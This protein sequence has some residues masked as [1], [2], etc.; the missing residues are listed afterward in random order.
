MPVTTATTPVLE[1]RSVV[2][3]YGHGRA[4]HHALNG[5][6]CVVEPGQTLGVVGESGSGKSTLGEVL[7]GLARPQGGEVLFE[8][9]PVRKLDAAGR[10]RYRRNVQFVFQDPQASM[11]P[12]YTVGR[13][14]AEPLEMFERDLTR[15]ERRTRVG[16]ML[17][18]VGLTADLLDKRPAELSGGQCQRVAIARAL[19]ARPAV[20][21][22]DEATSALDVSVQAQVLNLLHDLQR[23]LGC[24]CV[25]ISHD[26]AVV[27]YVAARVL[28][29]RS[30]RV[31]EEGPTP[32]VLNDPRDPYV[33]E[34]VEAA[35]A[36]S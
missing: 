8:G 29:L 12:G 3:T 19:V 9:V 13:V 15:A 10:R 32:A 11:D 30:G 18:R 36:C 22:C 24:A 6:S 28:V 4:A 31:V 34:L 14:V 27:S 16:Q 23:E 7:G 20:V 5:V 35:R 25:F 21:V 1:A 33:R 2:R 17:E 26:I